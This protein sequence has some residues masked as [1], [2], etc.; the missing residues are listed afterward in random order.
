MKEVV[1]PTNAGIQRLCRLPGSHWIPA[2][3]GM[4]SRGMKETGGTRR[5][6]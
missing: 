4:T 6:E 5:K 1:I 2:F 3:A